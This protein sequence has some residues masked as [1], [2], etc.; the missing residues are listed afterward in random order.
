[1]IQGQIYNP[2]KGSNSWSYIFE[3][4]TFFLLPNFPISPWFLGKPM[5]FGEASTIIEVRDVGIN[6]DVGFF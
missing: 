1:M 3:E 2:E 6:K 5:V 4:T